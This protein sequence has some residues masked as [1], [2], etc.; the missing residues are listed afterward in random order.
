MELAPCLSA[1]AEK[2][3]VKASSGHNPLPFLISVSRTLIR[4]FR[5]FDPEYKELVQR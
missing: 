1:V 3:V 2:Q 5:I 4:D